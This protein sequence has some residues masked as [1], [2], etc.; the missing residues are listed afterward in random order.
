MAHVRQEFAFRGSGS[1]GLVAGDR[2]CCRLFLEML[3]LGRDPRLGFQ[4]V[5]QIALA[6]LPAGGVRS[7]RSANLPYVTVAPSASQTA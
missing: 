3:G 5:L 1:F 4:N 7:H 2:Q 6:S